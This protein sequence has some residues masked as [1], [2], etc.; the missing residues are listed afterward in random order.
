MLTSQS[1]TELPGRSRVEELSWPELDAG[2]FSVHIALAGG[3]I[4]AASPLLSTIPRLILQAGDL[5]TSSICPVE[6]GTPRRI[7][8]IALDQSQPADSTYRLIA[9]YST[10][11][12]SLFLVHPSKLKDSREMLT[13]T[14]SSRPSRSGTVIQA[15][16]HHP[17]LVVLSSRFDL[18]IYE[19]QSSEN[20]RRYEIRNRQTLTSFTSHLPTSLILSSP[21]PGIYKMILAYTVPIYPAHWTAGIT[22]VVISSFTV[23]STHSTTA[24]DLGS[25]WVP[26]TP[27][28]NEVLNEQ[29]DRKLASVSSVSTDGRYVVLASRTTNSIQLFRLSNKTREPGI[30]LTF[31]RN[32]HGHLSPVQAL[33]VSD[34]RCVS[35][36][37]DGSLWA[38]D[39]ERGGNVEVQTR[40]CDD[41]PAFP[42]VIFDERRILV[43]LSNR[44]IINRFDV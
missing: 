25:T 30:K 35:L 8:T 9:F 20:G 4:I 27:E 38:W 39:I 37:Q 23:Q 43:V 29:N 7:T 22:E 12:F 3:L 32:L 16:Y 6:Q 28:L 26:L 10:G 36:S 21:S 24:F 15:V 11:A 18:T 1:L 5:E 33:A 42:K 19:A 41:I 2:S 14:P 17:L 34:G 40:I 44:I 31:L 13:F